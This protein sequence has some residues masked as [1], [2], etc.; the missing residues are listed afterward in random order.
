MTPTQTYFKAETKLG[1]NWDHL[2]MQ[3]EELLSPISEF[4]G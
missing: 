4:L 2:E 1:N 3:N